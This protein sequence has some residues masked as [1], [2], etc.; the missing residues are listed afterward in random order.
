MITFK[1]GN[2]QPEEIISTLKKNAQLKE[3][4]QSLLYR[5]I[6]D[7]TVAERRI[8]VTPEE[9]Q[10]VADQLRY[11]K[12]LFRASDTF[13][14][15]EDQA[16]TAEDWE[17]GI[18]DRLLA[19]KL[20][21][22]LFEKEAKKYFAEHQADFDQV[23]LYQ[24]VVPYERLAQEIYYQIQEAEISFYEAAHV[25]DVDCQR[26]LQCGYEGKFYRWNLKP[27]VSALVF[28]AIP[29]NVIGPFLMEQTSHL[30][31]VE[32][33]IPAELTPERYQEILNRM[34]TEWLTTELNYQ[35]SV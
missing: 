19:E 31:M 6:I 4:C 10:I 35:L 26:R 16:I 28:S 5:Q 15:L 22:S 32:E 8:Y 17:A 25:Y 27:D 14:W 24:I 13:A 11:E 7:K 23:S 30:F 18:R 34:F 21:T 33:F 3:V 1:G 9:I 29:G 20:A 12:R 2:I